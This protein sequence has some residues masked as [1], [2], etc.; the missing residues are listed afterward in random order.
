MGYTLSESKSNKLSQSGFILIASMPNKHVLQLNFIFLWDKTSMCDYCFRQQIIIE[1]LLSARYCPICLQ[2]KGKFFKSLPSNNSVQKRKKCIMWGNTIKT[3][4]ALYH[5]C[6]SSA[7]LHDSQIPSMNFVKFKEGSHVC[8]YKKG[9]CNCSLEFL[10]FS[11]LQ[12]LLESSDD[13]ENF[14]FHMCSFDLQ[15]TYV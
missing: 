1:H 9:P 13:S 5:R 3:V 12:G 8:K 6:K 4:K 15:R 10:F 7:V 11:H 14:I 2:K